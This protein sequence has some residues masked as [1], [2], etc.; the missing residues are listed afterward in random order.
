MTPTE[1]E[2]LREIV[3]ALRKVYNNGNGSEVFPKSH[4]VGE[5][6]TPEFVAVDNALTTAEKVWGIK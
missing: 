2:A 6:A 5:E 3:G 1:L 4:V